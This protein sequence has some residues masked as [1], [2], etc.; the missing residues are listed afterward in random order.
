MKNADKQTI[1]EIVFYPST[2][3][4]FVPAGV[5]PKI[6]QEVV[7]AINP[8]IADGFALYEKTKNFYLNALG[9]DDRDYRHLFDEQAQEIFV[10]MDT[11]AEQLRQIGG[12]PLRSIS[13]SGELQSVENYNGDILSPAKMVEELIADN[14]RI[15]T[16]LRAAGKICEKMCDAP[17]GIILQDILVKTERRIR[18]LSEFEMKR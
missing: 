8:V 16:A 6:V 15:A 7:Q 5:E 17:I 14:R 13:H 2:L 1:E 3:S 10:S 11:L 4:G 12:V 9:A 18:L